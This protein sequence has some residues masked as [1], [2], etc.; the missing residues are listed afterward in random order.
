MHIALINA[1]AVK[2][3]LSPI[4]LLYL[5]AYL[6]DHGHIVELH[7]PYLD[8]DARSPQDALV[9]RL[10]R[11]PRPDLI[12][13]S[14]RNIDSAQMQQSRFF[15]PEADALIH[16]VR[17]AYPDVPMVLGG[18]GF[19]LEPAS[20]LELTGADYGIV[21]EGE[22][23]LAALVERLAARRA[24]DDV[25]GLVFRWDDG[26]LQ[27]NPPVNA[28]AEFL[29]HLPLQA[30]DLVDYERYFLHGGS[31]SVQTKRGCAQHCSYCTYPLI[32]GRSYR[33]IAPVRVVDEMEYLAG[34]GYDYFHFSDSVFNV[35]RKHAL[36][37]CDELS[38]RD[39]GAHWHAYTS[40][41][42]FDDELAARMVRAGSDGV[43]F[44]VDSCSDKILQS[45]GKNYRQRDIYSAAEACRRHGLEFSFHLLIGPPGE[46]AETL[47]ETLAVVDDIR[48]TAVFIAEGIRIYRGTPVQKQLIAR[49]LL[50]PTTPLLKPYFYYSEELPPDATRRILDFAQARDFVYCTAGGGSP[51]LNRTIVD[52]YRE[53]FRGPLWKILAEM[54]RRAR[55]EVLAGAA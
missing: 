5:A 55:R 17:A 7:D 26:S 14:I 50:S 15:L 49:G 13:F 22:L 11:G 8:D 45:Y 38:K 42:R 31:A 18:A 35:P 33:L 4:G 9:G 27:E 41:Y 44:G 1:N 39:L 24:V 43:Y 40:P 29:R 36:D 53:G 47:A 51:Q 23:A 20:I 16:A 37:V 32:E 3:P 52:L 28:D 12:G 34:K 30:L 2:P 54:K 25:P 21:G 10:R 19:S 6:R 48:P 46:N